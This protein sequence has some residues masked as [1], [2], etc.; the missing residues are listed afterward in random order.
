MRPQDSIVISNV[1]TAQTFELKGGA[2]GIAL[3]ATFGGGSVDVTINNGVADVSVLDATFLANGY[4][5][6]TVPPGTYK[7][8]PTT[9]TAVTATI[10]RIP[11]E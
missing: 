5:T 8:T 10:T 9:A 2:Y 7:L 11:G 6:I 1:S 3:N 4:K